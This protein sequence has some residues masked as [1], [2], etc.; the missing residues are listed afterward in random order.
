MAQPTDADWARLSDDLQQGD[1]IKA[2]LI[3]DKRAD[4]Q[5]ARS[6]VTM[7]IRHCLKWDTDKL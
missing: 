7:W 3:H 2:K 4:K 1:P 5:R 6:S